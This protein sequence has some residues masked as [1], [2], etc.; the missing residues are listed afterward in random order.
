MNIAEGSL[1]ECRYYLILADDLGFGQTESLTTIL[2][3][4]SRILN[5]YARAIL[6]PGFWLL[7]SGFHIPQGYQGRSPCLVSCRLVND[8]AVSDLDFEAGFQQM[9]PDLL[10]DHHRAMLPAGA[11]ECYRQVTLP[12]ADIMRQ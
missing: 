8:I 2:E 6:A 10:R 11:A 9:L 3:E 12:L 7:T 5:A 1:E 4:T